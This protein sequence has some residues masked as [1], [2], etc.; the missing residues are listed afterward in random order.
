MK[1]TV[2]ILMAAMACLADTNK[3]TFVRGSM[4][5]RYSSRTD[6]VDG[7]PKPGATDKYTL[8][9]NISDSAV[10][11]GSITYTPLIAGL[12]DR[13]TQPASLS[14]NVDCDVVNPANP[15]QTKN[16]GRLY[17]L[18][19]IEASGVYKYTAGSL[20]VSVYPIGRA[21]GFDSK[22][23]GLASGKPLL[24]TVSLID[25]VKKEALSVTKQIQGRT[26]AIAVKKYDKMAFQHHTIGAGPVQ[27]YPE[28]TVN[29]TMIYDYD[30][31]A[32]Y[33]QGVQIAYVVDGAQRVDKLTGSIRWIESPHRR[34]N[35]EG[36]YQF[37]VRVNEP[38]PSESNVFAGATDEAAFF[39]TDD[40]IAALTGTMKYKDSLL[41][42]A[43]TSSQVKF[44]LNG[45]KLSR[46]QT[47]NLAKLVLFSCTVPMN[48]E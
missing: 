30:R 25:K 4:E 36:E 38:P 20:K 2:L 44:D 46:M 45:N 31:Y 17:G 33:F 1:T 27:Y 32:W 24:K 29:G 3:P 16:V 23:T 42:E 40:S 15:S 7:K 26:V 41:G 8:N 47:M 39:Q 19:P 35:G 43:V 21:Q 34:A 28:A 14:Y 10:F 11:R 5:I 12:L 48:A 9:V 6:Q 18:V 37:D 13:I 22:F